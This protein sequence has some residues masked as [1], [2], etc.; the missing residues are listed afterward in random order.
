MNYQSLLNDFVKASKSG[1]YEGIK[2]VIV[3]MIII[4]QKQDHRIADLEIKQELKDT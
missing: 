3:D 2:N 1:D 4:M